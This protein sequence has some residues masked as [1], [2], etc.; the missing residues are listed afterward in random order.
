MDVFK[1]AKRQLPE[2][3][4]LYLVKYIKNI[5][6]LNDIFLLTILETTKGKTQQN[7]LKNIC[8]FVIIVLE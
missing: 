8:I 3:K 7:S 4:H 5:K 1:L 6:G 2:T